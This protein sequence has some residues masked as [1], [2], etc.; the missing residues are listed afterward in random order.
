MGKNIFLAKKSSI[1]LLGPTGVG[2]SIVAEEL[3]KQTKLPHIWADTFR[4][5]PK[6]LKE[7]QR[8]IDLYKN[9]IE[10]LE[11][12]IAES[13]DDER[14]K[15]YL[16]ELNEFKKYLWRENNFLEQRKL[17]PDLPNYYDFGFDPRVANYFKNMFGVGAWHMYHKQFENM[18]LEEI[19]KRI[20]FPCILD[21]GGGM[22]ACPEKFYNKTLQNIENCK[23][24]FLTKEKLN[25]YLNLDKIKFN[26]IKNSL[27]DF[28]M[29]V[30]LVNSGKTSS[31]KM[32][33]EKELNDILSFSKDYDKIATYKVD[34]AKMFDEDYN[35]NENV[36]KELSRQI[37][38]KQKKLQMEDVLQR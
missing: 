34:T 1:V 9:R 17:F 23:T 31:Q 33:D 26:S 4:E 22:G 14:K 24:K 36:V 11:K 29:V 28:G 37:A 10:N 12:Q 32:Q 18:L 20:D 19:V 16:S 7:I 6:D 15:N 21:L 13:G 5:C 25:S 8:I 2:K 27:K 38:C 35:L 3:A 30:E